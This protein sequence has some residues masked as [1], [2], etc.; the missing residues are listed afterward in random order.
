M[1]CPKARRT[2]SKRSPEVPLP[3]C[4]T[5]GVLGG[6]QLGRM[7]AL[8]AARLGFRTHIYCPEAEAVAADVAARTTCAAYDDEAK[9]EAFAASVSVATYEFE[10][11]PAR[12]AESL[13]RHVAVHP[14]PRA[15][16]IAQDRVA[17][18]SFAS[19]LGIECAPFAAIDDVS[20]L[21]QAMDT[22]GL[23]ALLKTRRLGYDGKGQA[24]VRTA[25][26][27]REAWAKLGGV[28]AILEAVVPFE[29][30]VSV[31]LARGLDGRVQSF[32]P[33]WN[34]HAGGILRRS[35]VPAGLDAETEAQAKRIAM[36]LAEA[37]GYVGVLAVELFVMQEG[38]TVRL[39]FNE[40][41]PRVHNSGHWTLD[42]C[43]ISQF[44]QH[45]RAIAGWPLG[46]PVRHSDAVMDNLVGAEAEGWQR[47][48]S[49]ANAVLHLYGKR[50]L[51][52]GRKMGHVTRLYPLGGRPLD[53]LLRTL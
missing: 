2:M 53:G 23:P 4:S 48:A 42:A 45:V 37:L 27:A 19:S 40:L 41:A 20:A 34:I 1:L 18:K 39:L 44:E 21:A 28:P 35:I 6:G 43:A 31:V 8:A 9:L 5:I 22:T 15:L 30:E 3:P 52:P 50:V 25:G 49:E 33:S 17:E 16:A 10:N 7:L 51:R 26:E 36:R 24:L 14:R 32:D 47:L 13:A 38:D 29:R 11:V 12:T 46:A